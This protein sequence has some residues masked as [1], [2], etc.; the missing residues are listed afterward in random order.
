MN[1]IL[2]NK[3]A[4]YGG[5]FAAGGGFEPPLS[6]PETD[7]L[8]LDDPANC[9]PHFIMFTVSRLVKKYTISPFDY[10]SNVILKLQL[11]DCSK[12]EARTS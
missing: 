12:I 7:V 1:E 5:F 10:I 6:V 3:T 8:P 4:I 9:R 2:K 11:K